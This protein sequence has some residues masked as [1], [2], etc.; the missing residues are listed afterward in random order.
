MWANEVGSSVGQ[1]RSSLGR[2]GRQ[3][4]EV[5]CK[6]FGL[7]EERKCLHTASREQLR[8]IQGMLAEVRWHSSLNDSAK[9]CLLPTFKK[10]KNLKN[11][12][13][14]YICK[15]NSNIITQTVSAL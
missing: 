10:M 8:G 13:K 11:S 2:V 14:E 9:L 7:I 6:G 12:I 15:R 5:T 4:S 1:T 3:E